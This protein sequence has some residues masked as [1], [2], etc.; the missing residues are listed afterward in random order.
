MACLFSEYGAVVGIRHNQSAS[1]ADLILRDIEIIGG[2][3]AVFQADLTANSPEEIVYSFVNKF[4]GMDVLVNNAGA[5]IG[6]KDILGLDA[7][8]WDKTYRLENGSQNR[9]A[10]N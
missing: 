2:R 9:Q 4:G 10:S 8:S 1:E 7:E 3:G 5:V 6:P